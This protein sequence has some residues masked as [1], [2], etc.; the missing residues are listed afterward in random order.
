MRKEA[1]FSSNF[2]YVRA[3]TH[4]SGGASYLYVFNDD[5]LTI[6][7]E[8]AKRSKVEAEVNAFIKRI[9]DKKKRV[10]GQLNTK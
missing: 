8:L 1:W 5:A 9:N 7:I 4:D 3:V 6:S 2:S 10:V